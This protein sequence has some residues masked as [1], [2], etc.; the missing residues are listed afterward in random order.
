MPVSA[1][2]RVARVPGDV[3]ARADSIRRISLLAP[4]PGMRVRCSVRSTYKL[5]LF[6]TIKDRHRHVQEHNAKTQSD[7]GMIVGGQADLLEGTVLFI[8]GHATLTIRCFS[9]FVALIEAPLIV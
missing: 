7:E 4:T 2:I 6:F 9:I 5:S 1:S 8:D 3:L